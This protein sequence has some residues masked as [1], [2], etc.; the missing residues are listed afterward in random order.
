VRGQ[1][2]GDAGL[3]RGDPLAQARRERDQLCGDGLGG[4][5]GRS[6]GQPGRCLAQVV[7]QLG[8]GAG[9]RAAVVGGVEQDK[10]L[11]AAQRDINSDVWPTR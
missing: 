6:L 3:E 7:E 4:V 8:G 1:G 5:G 2:V 10:F 11:D 9:V